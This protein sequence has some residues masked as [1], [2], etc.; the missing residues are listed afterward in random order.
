MDESHCLKTPTCFTFG[1]VALHHNIYMEY[2]INF[3]FVSEKSIVVVY[4]VGTLFSC[5]PLDIL[6]ISTRG[7]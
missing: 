6:R 5:L 4:V 1:L 3:I 2:L 7:T